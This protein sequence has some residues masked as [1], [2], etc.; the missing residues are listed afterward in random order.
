MNIDVL[1]IGNASYDVFFPLDSYP[2]ENKK[3][4]SLTNVFESGGG[5]AANA[6]YL[7]AKWGVNSAFMGLIGNDLNG[8]AILNEYKQVGMSTDFIEIRDNYATPL[9]GIIINKNNGSRTIICRRTEFSQ[10]RINRKQLC[11]ISPRI[12]LFDGYELEASLLALE[13]YPHAVSILDAGSLREAT[14][15]LAK[16]VNYLICSENFA[17]DYTGVKEI[18]TQVHKNNCIESMLTLK[19]N[20][21]ITLGERGCLYNDQNAIKKTDA[22]KLNTIDTTAAGDIFHGAFAYTQLQGM[23]LSEAILFSTITAGISV[24]RQGSRKSIPNISEVFSQYNKILK[25]TE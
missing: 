6:S 24:T 8:Q 18:S 20:T 5:P 12:L 10:M 25:K 3:Y 15:L 4:N 14:E 1:C 7:L 21:V 11:K 2:E 22:M 9:S 17:V 23:P 19:K 16:K 13:I